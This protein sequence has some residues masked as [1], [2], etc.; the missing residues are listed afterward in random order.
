MLMYTDS[1]TMN[2]LR[3]IDERTSIYNLS[4]FREDFVTLRL[5]IPPNN[6]GRF[7]DMDFDI[8][9]MNYILGNDMIF[10]EFFRI[11]YDLYIGKDVILLASKEDWSENILESLLKLIQ[12]RYGYNAILLD[13][14]EDY[15]YAKNEGVGGF[16][17]GYGLYNL[18]QD[19][20]RF[21]YLIEQYRSSYN[22]ALPFVLEGWCIPDDE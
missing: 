16:I 12:Q 9:Y 6:I 3:L 5:L 1:N 19:K 11:I 7:T 21:T 18:D 17:Q 4:T 22:G 10:C 20:E 2:S 8:A 13:S 15:I 14:D